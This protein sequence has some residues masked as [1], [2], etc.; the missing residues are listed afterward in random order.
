V[1]AEL[2]GIGL[3]EGEFVA[4]LGERDLGATGADEAAFLIRPNT[5]LAFAPVAETASGGELSRIALAI[6]AVAG[7]ET[8][9]SDEIDARIGGATPHPVPETPKALPRPAQVLED[10]P[11]PPIPRLAHPPLPGRQ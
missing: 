1:S 2:Q 10:P 9:V 4:V 5:G 8:M 3:G 7:A 11:P 6:A